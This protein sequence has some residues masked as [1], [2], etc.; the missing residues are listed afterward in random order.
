MRM[1]MG[2][3]VPP[4]VL[5]LAAAVADAAGSHRAAFY[6][7]LIAVPFAAGAAL[8]AAGDL[9][10]GRRAGMRTVCTATA[11]ALLVLSSA[12]RSNTPTDGSLPA[13]AVSALFACV[14]AY[15]SLG[16]VWVAWPPRP[17]VAHVE[18]ATE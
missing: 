3:P 14:A 10:D 6:L 17:A 7:V 9:A 8:S 16:L 15:I 11:L 18:T 5:A 2:S 13:L 12:V 1:P 4:L